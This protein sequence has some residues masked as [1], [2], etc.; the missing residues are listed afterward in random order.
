[1]QGF[2]SF[3]D[4]TTLAQRC[5]SS[6]QRNTGN[7]GSTYI[8][9]GM[10]FTC[11]GEVRRWRVAA[12]EIYYS[13]RSNRLPTLQIWREMPPS[14]STYTLATEIPLVSCNGD[15]YDV[16]IGNGVYECAL[17]QPVL[18]QKGD[19]LGLYLSRGHQNHDQIRVLFATGTVLLQTVYAYGG[20]R[21]SFSLDSPGTTR[22]EQALPLVTLD[23]ASNGKYLISHYA[24]STEGVRLLLKFKTTS[25][26]T[27]DCTMY[28]TGIAI[29]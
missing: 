21:S 29:G 7:Q 18:V 28:A 10:N 12:S 8:I 25:L 2:P 20:T 19:I 26:H 5:S 24:M 6:C 22:T 11:N 3:Q 1:M 23:V 4:V 9:P 16:I 17:N 14:S 27:G 13:G 15:N